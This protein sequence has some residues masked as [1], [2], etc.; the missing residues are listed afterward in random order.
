MGSRIRRRQL[1]QPGQQSPFDAVDPTAP[2][3]LQLRDNIAAKKRE[4]EELERQ[5][6]EWA[7]VHLEAKEQIAVEDRV[8]ALLRGQGLGA[9]LASSDTTANTS[10]PGM[11]D[12]VAVA[13]R[14][15]LASYGR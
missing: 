3:L 7:L 9:T 6:R 13:Q 12:A 14:N 5:Q 11:S 10:Q 8:R 2:Q 4:D 15:F 1:L